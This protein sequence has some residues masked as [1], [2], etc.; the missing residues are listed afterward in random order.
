MGNTPRFRYY[1]TLF[2]FVF[3]FVGINVYFTHTKS[4]S[5]IGMSVI[6][7]FIGGYVFYNA[8]TLLY[9]PK[10]KGRKHIF[11]HGKH[12]RLFMVGTGMFIA[13]MVFVGT[14]DILRK[15]HPTFFAYS[16]LIGI[17]LF[18]AS[19]VVLSIASPKEMVERRLKELK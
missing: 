17:P 9:K 13:S 19:F 1:I 4:I 5:S 2:I 11:Y 12:S 3:A 6:L 8:F 15:S 18:F 10:P 14:G 16:F 7:G